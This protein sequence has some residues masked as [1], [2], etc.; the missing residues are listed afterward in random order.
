MLGRK[1]W[2]GSWWTDNTMDGIFMPMS[3]PRRLP[4]LAEGSTRFNGG[5]TMGCSKAKL[6]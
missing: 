5:L 4:S 1:K 3:V 2:R 6:V